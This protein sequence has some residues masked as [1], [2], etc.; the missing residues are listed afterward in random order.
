MLGCRITQE[1]DVVTKKKT[2]DLA[3][4]GTPVDSYEYMK[5][6]RIAKILGPVGMC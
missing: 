6:S 1:A 5:E 2:F 3:F 4:L